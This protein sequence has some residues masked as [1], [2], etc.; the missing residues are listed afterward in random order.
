[1]L[2]DI[3]QETTGYKQLAEALVKMHENILVPLKKRQDEAKMILREFKDLHQEYEKQKR[4]LK[5]RSEIK[6]E[7]AY[8]LSYI[9]LVNLIAIPLLEASAQSDTVQGIA[10]NAESNILGRAS[11]AV[12]ETLISALESFI[13]GIAKAAGFF[14]TMENELKVLEAKA[15]ESK[16]LQRSYTIR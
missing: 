15:D 4:E 13:I 7:W 1:M 3:L 6:I 10:K 9:P 14:S 11:L 5:A 8:S 16:R 12:S 2:S